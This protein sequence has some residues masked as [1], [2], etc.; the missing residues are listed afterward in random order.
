MKGMKKMVFA[1]L[2]CIVA[3]SLFAQTEV[4]FEKNLE[5]TKTGL[6]NVLTESADIDISVWNKR[7]VMVVVRGLKK[8]EKVLDISVTENDGGI[9][10]SVKKAENRKLLG[11]GGIQFTSVEILVPESWSVRG[12]RRRRYQNKQCNRFC[13][14]RL[15][16]RRYNG[17]SNLRRVSRILGKRGYFPVGKHRSG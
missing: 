10:V 14:T 3:A 13:R 15:G 2:L 11:W 1:G 9:S 17:R 12:N 8:T 6:L 5:T 16:R 4:L 7:R